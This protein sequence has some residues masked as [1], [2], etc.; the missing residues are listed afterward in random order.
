[1]ATKT[2]IEVLRAKRK[3]NESLIKSTR[4]Q[5]QNQSLITELDKLKMATIHRNARRSTKWFQNKIMKGKIDK[6]FLKTQVRI[7]RMYAFV[8][9]AKHKDTLPHWDRHPLVIPISHYGDG[10]LGLNLHYLHPKLR[11]I[12]LNKLDQFSKGSGEQKRLALSYELLKGASGIK[13]FKPCIKRYLYSHVKTRFAV[14]PPSEQELAA[15][16]PL[17]SFEGANKDHVYKISREKIR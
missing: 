8:Y 10:F 7:G 5:Y 15:F 1:M 4:R 13:E 12:L 2:Q 16:M 3:A 9:D 14:I 6:K 11:I 17:A